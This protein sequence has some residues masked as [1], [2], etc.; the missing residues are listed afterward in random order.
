MQDCSLS[1][2]YL[3]KLYSYSSVIFI[4]QNTFLILFIALLPKLV[5]IPCKKSNPLYLNHIYIFNH[6]FLNLIF[7]FI[8][9]N[10]KVLGIFLQS[11]SLSLI[12]IIWPPWLYVK[13]SLLYICSF[14]EQEA[15]KIKDLEDTARKTSDCVSTGSKCVCC[16]V[17]VWNAR[18]IQAT[19]IFVSKTVLMEA[20]VLTCHLENENSE[21]L[22]LI[23]PRSIVTLSVKR[24]QHKLSWTVLLRMPVNAAN[25]YPTQNWRLKV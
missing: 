24:V 20:P 16:H 23:S 5:Y 19:L 4:V 6:L 13:L 25:A 8:G 9:M 10:L 15:G 7:H 1:K 14:P 2:N 17:S 21:E 22:P 18:K 11:N 12:K 3:V